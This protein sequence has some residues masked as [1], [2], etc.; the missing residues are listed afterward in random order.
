MAHEVVWNLDIYNEFVRI[1]CLTD[2]E[3]DVIRTRVIDK[4]SVV[5]QSQELGMSVSKVN[6]ITKKLKIKYDSAQKNSTI[7]P[8][9]KQSVYK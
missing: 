8:P 3:K 2:D 4:W 5:K 1:A 7:L 6:K 9:R